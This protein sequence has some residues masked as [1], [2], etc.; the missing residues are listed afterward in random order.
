M[1]V[2]VMNSKGSRKLT[3][4]EFDQCWRRNPH[5]FGI[6][7]S[8]NDMVVSQKTME[9][10][11]A[12]NLYNEV[13]ELIDGNVVSHFRFATHWSVG[14]ANTHP[15]DCGLDDTGGNMMMVH[16]GIL[17][18]SSK[19]EPDKSDTRLLCDILKRFPM[20]YIKRQEYVDAINKQL[21][22]DKILIMSSNWDVSHFG[23]DWVKIDDGIWA[24]N[25]APRIYKKTMTMIDIGRE[26]KSSSKKM[27]LWEFY[28]IPSMKDEDDDRYFY[29]G[30]LYGDEYI[31]NRKWY[32][33]EYDERED[34][35]V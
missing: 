14:I 22:W 7:Y 18:Y 25:D 31:V 12:F 24:S 4:E 33:E 19:T 8:E 1:C 3:L 16:N 13:M 5:G 15:F 32:V 35:T 6:M 21:S 20:G 29:N 11:S 23:A 9:L 17:G 34:I 30:I 2:I 28:G 27:V 26:I 10:E